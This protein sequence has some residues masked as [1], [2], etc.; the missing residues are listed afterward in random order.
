ISI[1]LK[2]RQVIDLVPM[3]NCS[4]ITK[5]FHLV[6]RPCLQESA[7]PGGSSMNGQKKIASVIL[8]TIIVGTITFMGAG[9]GTTA[10]PWPPNKPGLR[11]MTT[12]PPLYC[13]AA[14]VAGD[15]ATVLCLLDTTGPHNYTVTSQE[16]QKLLRANLFLINGL[17]LDD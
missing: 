3:E 6:A 10:D 4:S 5:Y 17:E 8:G 11:I 7:G 16:A 1:I 2:I 9:C 12:F 15:D 13:F 14:N